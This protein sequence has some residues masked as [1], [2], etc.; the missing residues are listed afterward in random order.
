M[1]RK[2]MD[3]TETRVPIEQVEVNSVAEYD[4]ETIPVMDCE[5][6]PQTIDDPYSYCNCPN[7]GELHAYHVA[8]DSDG[9]IRCE[10]CRE[11]QPV[12]PLEEDPV[13][14]EPII[15]E[16]DPEDLPEAVR[17][18]LVFLA[19]LGVGE[20]RERA[21]SLIPRMAATRAQIS[22]TRQ[23]LRQLTVQEELIEAALTLSEAFRELKN[24]PSRKAWLAVQ[25]LNDPDFGTAIRDRERAQRELEGSEVALQVMT[26]ELGLIRSEMRLVA[27][28]LTFLAEGD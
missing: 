16:I 17:G 18:K 23:L 22:G 28:Q 11:A 13:E 27:A 24:D 6:E 8:M 20:L 3:L 26:D 9:R 12:R 15:E 21:N 4:S 7:C 14:V 10:A 2:R 19:S 1:R 25:R 5:D